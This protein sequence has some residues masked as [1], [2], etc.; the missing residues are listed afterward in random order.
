MYMNHCVIWILNVIK[1]ILF[2]MSFLQFIWTLKDICT[3]FTQ[4]AVT[5]F[6]FS[7]NPLNLPE[8]LLQSMTVCDLYHWHSS[9]F[10]SLSPSNGCFLWLTQFSPHWIICIFRNFHLFLCL[11]TTKVGWQVVFSRGSKIL[12]SDY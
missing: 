3:N 12:K 2:W 10:I 7:D 5:L 9:T 11:L 1:V 8:H 6:S 4:Q